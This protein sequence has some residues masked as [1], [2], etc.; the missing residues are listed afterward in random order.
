MLVDVV[1]EDVVGA[2]L[3]LDVLVELVVELEVDEVVVVLVVLTGAIVVVEPMITMPSSSS[4]AAVPNARP[5]ASAKSEI[6]R[7]QVVIEILSL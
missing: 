4:Q 5:P 6:F 2:M 1:E 3:V 7:I